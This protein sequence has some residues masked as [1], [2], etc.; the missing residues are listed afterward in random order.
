MLDT[1]TLSV[2]DAVAELEDRIDDI[3]DTLADLDS[4]TERA[5]SLAQQAQTVEYYLD[6][7]E[8]H[9]DSDGWGD[10]CTLTFGAP[11]AGERALMHRAM[12]DDVGQETRRVWWVAAGTEE[13][14]YVVDDDDPEKALRETWDAVTDLHPA[15]VAW[16]ERE[17]DTVATPGETGNRLRRSLRERQSDENSPT[18][19]T[20]ST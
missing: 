11:T 9:R 4:S 16:A 18:G 13:A 3:A 10:D 1:K 15:F 8:W 5:E 17:I 6:G 20:S 19:D 12:D 7:L 2:G 14:P